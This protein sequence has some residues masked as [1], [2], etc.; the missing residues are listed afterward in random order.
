VP[1]GVAVALTVVSHDGKSHRVLVRTAPP[2]AL[3]LP[4]GGKVSLLLTGLPDGS[5]VLLVDRRATAI[6][7]VGAQ[8]GP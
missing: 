5:Y 3:N 1:S 6:L 4:A 8:P 7:Q 2:H